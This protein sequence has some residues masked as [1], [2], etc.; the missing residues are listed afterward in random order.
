M[1][2]KKTAKKS[3]LSGTG[4]KRA[5][6]GKNSGKPKQTKKSKIKAVRLF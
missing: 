5:K 6:H 4:I 3:G 2:P 1:S